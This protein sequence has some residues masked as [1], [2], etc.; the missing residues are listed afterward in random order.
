MDI[1]L[2]LG[3]GGSRGNA[4]IGVIRRLEHEGFRIRGVA[5]TS[6]GG[7]VGVFYA[8][9]Y[10]PNDLEEMFAGLDQRSLYGHGP[11]DGPSLIGYAGVRQSLV[12]LLGD[13]TFASLPIPFAVTATDL[14]SGSEVVLSSGRLVEAILAT[15]AMPGIFPARHIGDRELVDGGTLDPVPVGPAR[16][17]APHLPVIAVSLTPPIGS[18][19]RTWSVPLPAFVP[20]AL[21]DRF[22]RMRYGLMLDVVM[23]S[24]DISNRAVTEYRLQMDKPDVIIRPRVGNIDTLDVINVPEVIK[25]GEEAVDEVLPQLRQKFTLRNRI[26]R[27]LGAKA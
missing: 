25:I 12:N 9:G 5:G 21:V 11:E 19:A 16:A 26:R 1:T 18:A 22:S 24:M 13:R 17:L 2:A 7:I 10:R 8:A 27:A 4:H 3:G 14:K 23:R 20:R 15:I 6:F